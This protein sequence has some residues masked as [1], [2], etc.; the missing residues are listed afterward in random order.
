MMTGRFDLDLE[1]Q[2]YR[3]AAER[4][5]QIR[6]RLFLQWG[7]VF[8]GRAMLTERLEELG[9]AMNP[10]TCRIEGI[11]IF[12]D[13]AIG[14]ATAAIYGNFLTE[15]KSSGQLIYAPERLAAMIKT[16]DDAGYRIAI[17]SIGDRATDLVMDGYAKTLDSVRHRI[18]HAMILSDGQIQRMAL[19]GCHCAM[20]P[21]FMR[22]FGHA[23][24]AQLGDD[25]AWKLKRM[26]SV[27]DAGIPLSLNSDRPIVA[28]DPWDG[29]NSAVN[30]PEGFDPAESL[31]LSEAIR[32]YTEMGAV[33]NGDPDSQG[34]LAPGFLADFNIV[35][36]LG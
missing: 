21:E 24:R 30:R 13:G 15:P 35:D 5:N 6:T 7:R 20:Q 32:G 8:G 2:A 10:D 14:S 28:G 34:Q 22:R 18:E 29:I 25:R 33:A 12:A 19:L 9:H 4:G 17:H 16:A 26:R 27:L 36:S 11:K 3:I 23:Y 31:T 1:L